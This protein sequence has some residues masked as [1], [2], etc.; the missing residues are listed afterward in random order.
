M[1]LALIFDSAGFG[2][3]FVLLAVVL[4]AVG[5]KNLPSAA[6]KLG[7][8]YGKIRRASEGFR[9]QLAEM[10]YEAERAARKAE[11]EVSEAFTSTGDESK[12]IPRE[13]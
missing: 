10:E 4:V 12:V 9:R 6:R 1:V 2:E 11:D 13:I 3:W 8:I 5:P 7:S